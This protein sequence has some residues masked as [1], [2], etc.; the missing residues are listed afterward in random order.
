MAGTNKTGN[1]HAAGEGPDDAGQPTTTIT[2]R[3]S[4]VDKNRDVRDFSSLPAR[5]AA[6]QARQSQLLK[7][8]SS[9]PKQQ[10]KQEEVRLAVMIGSLLYNVSN[11]P[12][13]VKSIAEATAPLA[14]A[15]ASESSE[16]TSAGSITTEIP[17]QQVERRRENEAKALQS[18]VHMIQNEIPESASELRQSRL[19]ES[20]K[21][22]VEFQRDQY[23]VGRDYATMAAE[24]RYK[25]K[26]ENNPDNR[27]T[28]VVEQVSS[29]SSRGSRRTLASLAKLLPHQTEKAPSPFPPPKLPYDPTA[30]GYSQLAQ[31]VSRNLLPLPVVYQAVLPWF[32][33]IPEFIYQPT[34]NALVS[35]IL[36]Q[37]SNL[38][39]ILK[40]RLLIFLDNPRNRTAM[41]TSTRGFFLSSLSSLPP[42]P[43]PRGKHK[44]NHI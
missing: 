14:S 20:T 18:I 40:E 44:T 11:D 1:N 42:S 12:S 3:S 16:F 30:L 4:N 17:S 10:R 7:Q 27:Q 6:V 41:K 29:S 21:K 19:Y 39:H 22:F 37:Q 26:T 5:S 31:V 24:Q 38:D 13:A 2:P 32:C 9:S 34:Q 15:S 28:G 8:P 35:I 25:Q 36:G 23:L 33:R 43:P